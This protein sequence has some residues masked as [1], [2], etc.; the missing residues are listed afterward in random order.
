MVLNGGGSGSSL[1]VWG[2]FDDDTELGEM[3]LASV[4]RSWRWTEH[5]M[6]TGQPLLTRHQLPQD[7]SSAQVDKPWL[8][9]GCFSYQEVG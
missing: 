8:E 4:G 9:T 5:A 1:S 2:H 6:C 3:L 7:A